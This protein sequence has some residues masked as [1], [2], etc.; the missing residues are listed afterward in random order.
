MKKLLALSLT[1]AAVSCSM[2]GCSDS[3]DGGDKKAENS[4]IDQN[5]LGAWYCEEIGGN[6][7]FSEDNTIAV[8]VD[9]S[10]LMYF[11]ADKNL[12][13]SGVGCPA[14]YDG[15]TLAVVIGADMTGGEETEMFTLKRTGEANADSLDGEYNL[16][17]GSLY[18]ELSAL[19]EGG[20]EADSIQMA[21]DGE[22]LEIIMDFSEYK[23]DGKKLEFIETSAN[24]FEFENEEEAI[25][26]YVIDG[27]KLTITES[28]GET[29]E[30]TKAE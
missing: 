7:L 26:D 18:D 30:L 12:V 22:S 16:V 15:T 11:D 8:S 17:S 5:L 14:E 9:Y 27:D 13:I 3:K 23:A 19:Y 21:I 25:C 20:I 10:E 6:M 28:S 1:L 24:F 4:T 29:M 2:F